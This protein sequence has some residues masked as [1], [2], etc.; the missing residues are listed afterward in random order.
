[1]LLTLFLSMK[2]MNCLDSV[3]SR[4]FGGAFPTPCCAI[5]LMNSVHVDRGGKRHLV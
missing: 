3:N 4:C 2:R 1:V 5:I